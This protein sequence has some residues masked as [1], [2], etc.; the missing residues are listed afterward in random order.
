MRRALRA[1]AITLVC[2]LAFADVGRAQQSADVE[3]VNALLDRFAELEDA[4]DETAQAALMAEDRVWIAQG[5]GRRT[6]QALNT[7]IQQAQQDAL[8]QAVPGIRFFTDYRDR[9]IRFYGD[10]TVAVASFYSYTTAVLPPNT[11]PN[12][13]DELAAIPP[14]AMTVV[15]ERRGQGWVVVHVHLSDLGPA[16]SP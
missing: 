10:G 16:P 13:A 7:Q 9:L 11:P 8:Q 14:A 3:A 2:G 1:L 12:F 4:M 5:E 15:L 6:N